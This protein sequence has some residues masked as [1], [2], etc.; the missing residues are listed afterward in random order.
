MEIQ[1]DTSIFHDN[2]ATCHVFYDHSLFHAYRQIHPPIKVNGFGSKLSATAPGE[3]TVKLLARV[4]NMESTVVLND[5]LHVPSSRV[6]LVSGSSLNKRGVDTWTSKGNISLLKDGTTFAR[7]S[8][9]KDLYKLDLMPIKAATV[10]D[11]GSNQSLLSRIEL[12]SLL[13]QMEIV[14]ISTTKS[15]KDPGFYTT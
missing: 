8:L 2:G 15:F 5:I 13:Q 6:H 1:K 7:G 14:A 3:G 10:S 11:H 4:G 9:W 12:L